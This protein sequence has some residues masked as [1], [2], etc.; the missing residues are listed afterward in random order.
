MTMRRRTFVHTA[1]VAAAG[2]LL[3]PRTVLGAR[4][5]DLVLRGAMVFDGSGA[6]GREMDVAVTG[7]RITGVGAGLP[8]GSDEMDLRGLALA[9]GFIDIHSHADMSLF[10][11]PNAES[12]IRQG[13]TLEVVGQ[14]GGSVGPW[15][16]DEY[17]E[18]RE[19][20]RSRYGADIDF[21]DPPGFLNGI[22]RLCPTVNVA[23]MVGNGA[24][25]GFVVGNENRPATDAELARMAQEVRRAVNGGCGGVSSGPG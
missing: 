8:A 10:I 18:T 11:N 4:R 12:R 16:E 7:D 22:D 1:G 23:T 14:D 3:N 24:V 25:R 9:P 21:R 17:Q 5:A 15:S 13:V 2:T 19:S 6:P 20:Y